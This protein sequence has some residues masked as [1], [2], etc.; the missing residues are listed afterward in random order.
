M[1]RQPPHHEKAPKTA[2]GAFLR[3]ARKRLELSQIEVENA[4][5]NRRPRRGAANPV[6]NWEAGALPGLDKL[7]RLAEV[8]QVPLPE[9]WREY[10]K[11]LVERAG[12]SLK[13]LEP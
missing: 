6:A 1:W 12:L 2:F 9:L 13:D 8:L 3:E 4:V 10:K 11:A 7:P 5:H